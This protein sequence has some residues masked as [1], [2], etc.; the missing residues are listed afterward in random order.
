[1]SIKLM[2]NN[3]KKMVKDY[4][5]YVVTLTVS[6]ALFFAFISLSSPSNKIIA[7]GLKY[8]KELFS[9][10]INTTIYIISLIFFVL[11]NYVNNHMLKRRSKE[12]SI[13]M[14]L[15][16]EQK[17]IAFS[18]FIETLEIGIAS[19]VVGTLF[20]TVLSGVLTSIVLVATEGNFQYRLKVY[21]DVFVKTLL[22]FLVVF[23]IVGIFNS[24]KLVKQKLI[25][26]I[27]TEKI[28]EGHL[29]RKKSYLIS[30]FIS[31]FS[32]IV[33]SITINKYLSVGSDYMD[34]IPPVISNRYQ[35]IIAIMLII[36]IF[37]GYYATSYIIGLFQKKSIKYKYRRLNVVFINNLFARISSNTKIA[38][39]AT[40][41]MAIS[42]LGF[43]IAPVLADI[44]EE[45]LDYRI[46]YDLMINNSYRYI[47][48]LRDIPKIEY[49]FI[50]NILKEHG[51]LIEE[52][53]EQQS[54]FVWEEAFEPVDVRENKWD[55]PRL[56]ISVS[57]Y[58][59]MRKMAGYEGIFLK[60]DEFAIQVSNEIDTEE[61]KKHLQTID[62]E[63]TLDDGTKMT[64]LEDAIYDVAIGTYLYN[65]G[66]SSS[67]IFSDSV[68]E[69]L[70]LANTCYYANTITTIPI[71]EC[72]K[73]ES[74]IRDTFKKLY[75]E[76]YKKYETK[77]NS[78]KDYQDFIEPI[79]FKTEEIN[80]VKLSSV[81][82]RLLGVY[83]G[84]IF[85]VI[86]LTVLALQQLSDADSN[87]WQYKTLY[88]IGVSKKEI[89]KMITKQI[90]LFFAIPCILSICGAGIG[91]YVF[92]LR[93]GHKVETYIGTYEFMLNIIIAIVLLVII[94]IAYFVGTV[95]GYHHNIESAF[96]TSYRKKF[97]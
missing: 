38:A 73:I 65:F 3:I 55:M 25:D 62:N 96:E 37:S 7:D 74:K 82:I 31:I 21:P 78:D 80:S 52:S 6:A 72:H 42:I 23:F 46:P 63:I 20:G 24:K 83:I 16:M 29:K 66:N 43:V 35:T 39:S 91:I 68:C 15:G 48:K 51:I 41:A 50:N 18:Y 45:Y 26:L 17:D 95:K 5:I 27:N 85:F 94:F 70:H 30:L 77:Y 40:I 60:D 93:F 71:S 10:T 34:N 56:A 13:Y 75:P 88:N 14:I 2:R 11:V 47:D 84:V 58:N 36:G 49:S 86:C 9:E 53:C 57:D 22:F 59:K 1:M 67:L 54:Y 87:R 33:V 76:L 12:F 97:N 28:S 89:H 32:F 92:M 69:K 44:S 8:S 19:V 90:S 81:C 4:Q 61:L 64:M 79:R